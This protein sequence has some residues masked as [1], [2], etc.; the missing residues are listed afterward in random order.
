[1]PNSFKGDIQIEYVDADGDRQYT[2]GRDI[3]YNIEVSSD[4][5]NEQYMFL[6]NFISDIKDYEPKR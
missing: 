2:N 1:M 4:T 6:E 5:L 3:L